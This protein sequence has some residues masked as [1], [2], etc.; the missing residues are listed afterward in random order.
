MPTGSPTPSGTPPGPS[1]VPGSMSPDGHVSLPG[2]CLR[3][4][5]RGRGVPGQCLCP[6]CSSAPPQPGL[7]VPV[8]PAGAGGH[9]RLSACPSP[10][11]SPG[12]ALRSHWLRPRPMWG[13]ATA[14]RD[15]DSSVR[16]GPRALLS[17]EYGQCGR[18]LTPCSKAQPHASA[19]RAPSQCQPSRA[20]RLR[21]LQPPGSGAWLVSSPVPRLLQVSGPPCVLRGDPPIPGRPPRT[22]VQAGAPRS[23]RCAVWTG[24][25]SRVTW[26]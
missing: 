7:G 11:P 24:D 8:P 16:P 6:L 9:P 13:G 3:S 23:T 21:P 25:G 19:G 4:L 17:G 14:A 12:P 15:R 18:S 5:A 26:S 2:G 22:T 10:G 1:S 20:P